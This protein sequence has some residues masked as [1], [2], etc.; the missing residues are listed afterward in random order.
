MLKNIKATKNRESIQFRLNRNERKLSTDALKN[1]SNCWACRLFNATKH[2]CEPYLPIKASP[3]VNLRCKTVVQVRPCLV[4][5]DYNRFTNSCLLAAALFECCFHCNVSEC[6][7]S[8]FG[9][10]KR[11]WMWRLNMSLCFHQLCE[12]HTHTSTPLHLYTSIVFT[13]F[14]RESFKCEGGAAAYI[15]CVSVCVCVRAP[16]CVHSGVV[17]NTKCMWDR[18]DVEGL[19]AFVSCLVCSMLLTFM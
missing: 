18:K 17:G 7:C 9:L 1:T 11:I 19:S 3:A 12:K 2:N 14:T 4:S 13:L 15:V 6:R 8:A 10:A 5:F 16:V